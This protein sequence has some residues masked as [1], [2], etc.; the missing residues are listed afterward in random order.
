[1][2]RESRERPA[3]QES[4]ESRRLED[5]R[6]EYAASRRAWQAFIDD[7]M[8]RK[9]KLAAAVEAGFCKDLD[10]AREGRARQAARLRGGDDGAVRAHER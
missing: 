4:E 10:A 1:M 9:A 8:D 5:A 3:K 6:A 7:L 2:V